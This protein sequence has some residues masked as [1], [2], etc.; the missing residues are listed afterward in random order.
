MNIDEFLAPVVDALQSLI[1]IINNSI[2]SDSV[3]QQL[4]DLLMETVFGRKLLM[5]S[6][7]ENNIV[8]F[9]DVYICNKCNTVHKRE[10]NA[11][12]LAIIREVENL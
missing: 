7:K 8:E 5:H 3:R 10:E 1:K 12:E 6:M 11:C 4:V 9:L 2:L